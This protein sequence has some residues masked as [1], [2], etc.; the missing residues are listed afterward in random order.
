MERVFFLLF[1]QKN[2]DGE[3][4][5]G[6]LGDALRELNKVLDPYGDSSRSATVIL[7]YVCSV[8]IFFHSELFLCCFEINLPFFT[9]LLKF[10]LRIQ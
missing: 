9:L 8:L 2:K 3:M 4:G 5:L 10:I 1:F 6:I 7:P